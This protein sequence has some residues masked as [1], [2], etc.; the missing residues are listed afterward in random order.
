MAPRSETLWDSSLARFCAPCCWAEAVPELAGDE[1]LPEAGEDPGPAGGDEAAGP[2]PVWPELCALAMSSP[3][4]I[5][6]ATTMTA[7]RP[8]MIRPR[9]EPRPAGAR[10]PVG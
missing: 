6:P 8:R 3:A 7:R 4:A 1:P 5:P 9:C 10:W 2:A